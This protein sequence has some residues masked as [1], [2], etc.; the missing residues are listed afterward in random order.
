MYGPAE[1]TAF[2]FYFDRTA[3]TARVNTEESGTWNP[4]LDNI[5]VKGDN[6]GYG[7]DSAYVANGSHHGGILDNNAE[8]Y[9][10]TF[11]WN[12][13][14]SGDELVPMDF[15]GGNVIISGAD[16][17]S[18]TAYTDISTNDYTFYGIYHQDSDV[19]NRNVYYKSS[20]A[21]GATW[22]NQYTLALS[23]GIADSGFTHMM[24]V[25]SQN[26]HNFLFHIAQWMNNNLFLGGSDR[27]YERYMALG[28]MVRH[29][30]IPLVI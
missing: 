25:E 13:T 24:F 21:G 18:V 23:Q 10:V 27:T 9:T 7:G 12:G 6:A 1:N 19:S 16:E 3:P 22:A 11:D 17:G 30:H 26:E 20:A 15:G 28:K 8:T 2:S 4:L 29:P 14:Q 5:I